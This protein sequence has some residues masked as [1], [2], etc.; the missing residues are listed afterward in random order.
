MLT[1]VLNIKEGEVISLI[2]AGGKTSIMFS[3]AQELKEIVTGRIITTTTTK[4]LEPAESASERLIVSDDLTDFLHKLTSLF[5]QDKLLTVVK[6]RIGTS[7]K[8]KGIPPDWIG[9]LKEIDFD[10]KITI[11]VEADGAACRDF[12]I[13]NE[14]EPVIPSSTDLLLPVIGSRIVNCRLNS[15]NLHR[16][17]LIDKINSDFKLEQMVT[18][19]L[20]VDILLKRQGYD[21]LTKQSQYRVIPILNQVDTEPRYNFARKVGEKLIESG[22]NMVLLTAVKNKKSVIEVLKR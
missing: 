16:V 10:N 9:K 18:A 2:G 3:L 6:E 4:I 17:S 15:K 13:P 1:K 8:L 7:D 14:N 12:K 5:P 22:I 21:L 11:I 19:E 20:I